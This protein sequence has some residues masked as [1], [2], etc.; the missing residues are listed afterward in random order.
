MTDGF[1]SDSGSIDCSPPPPFV[2]DMMHLHDFTALHRSV[3]FSILTQL[4]L[5]YVSL[6]C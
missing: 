2:T 1:T 6:T 4:I 3:Y 5:C